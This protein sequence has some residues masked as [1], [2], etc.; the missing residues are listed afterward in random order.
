MSKTQIDTIF[1]QASLPRRVWLLAV[2]VMN[3][4]KKCQL[5][6]MDKDK[7]FKNLRTEPDFKQQ[8]L[9]PIRTL[10]EDQQC[11][12]LQELID[13]RVKITELKEAAAKIKQMTLL[14][15]TFLELTAIKTWEEAQEMIPQ[16]A[17]TEQLG[18]FSGCDI[19]KSVPQFFKEFCSR[20]KSSLDGH[21]EAADITVIHGRQALCKVLHSKFTELCGNTIATVFPTFTGVQLTAV[22]FGKVHT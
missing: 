7:K 20:A 6:D 9:T 3:K 1:S 14:K 16:F 17:T 13:C 11:H 4:F 18:K 8:Y 19:K 5:K 21:C 12:L 2:Q 15:N 10:S 22:S